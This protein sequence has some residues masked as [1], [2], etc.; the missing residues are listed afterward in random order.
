M[1]TIRCFKKICTVFLFDLI[2]DISANN[3]YANT[4]LFT[5]AVSQ[6]Y[7]LFQNLMIFPWVTDPKFNDISIMFSFYKFY[8]LFMKFN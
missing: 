5:R 6:K 4:Y 7:V 3:V 8:E 2:C 1:T